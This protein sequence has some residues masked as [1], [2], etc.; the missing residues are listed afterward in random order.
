VTAGC[1]P[2]H[3]P[4]YYSF[5]NTTAANNHALAWKLAGPFRPLPAVRFCRG[6]HQWYVQPPVEAKP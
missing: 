3:D 1:E 4:G 2:S 5:P 6:C